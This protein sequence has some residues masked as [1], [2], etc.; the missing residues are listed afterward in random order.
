[1]TIWEVGRLES[2][3]EDEFLTLGMHF[4][5]WS[6]FQKLLLRS[7]L[8]EEILDGRGHVHHCRKSYVPCLEYSMHIYWRNSNLF[9]KL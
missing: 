7:P 1:M 9:I 4:D 5:M 2:L 3:A 8:G 6:D